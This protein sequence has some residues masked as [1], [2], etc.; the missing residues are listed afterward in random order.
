MHQELLHKNIELLRKQQPTLAMKLSEWQF[1]LGQLEVCKTKQGE[2]NLSEKV[3]GKICYFHSKYNA[4]KEAKDWFSSLN[5]EGVDVLYVYGIGM[6]HYYNA[7]KDWLD[8]SAGHYLVFIEDNL[9]V[10]R[11]FFNTEKATEVLE[12]KQVQ[13]HYLQSFVDSEA[14]LQWLSWFFVLLPID[15][16]GLLYYQK[17]KEKM[18]TQLRLKLMHDSVR[19]DNRAAEFMRFS[20]RFFK[21]FFSNTLYLPDSYHGNHLF[22]KFSGIP[23]IICGAGPSLDK[24]IAL[25]GKSL[26]QALVFSG[27]SALNALN[28]YDLLPH[29]SAGIDPNPAQY[30]RLFSNSSFELPFFYRGRMLHEAFRLIHGDRLYINGTGGYFISEWFEEKLGIESIIIDEGHN[31]VN[32]CVEIANA[33]GCNPIIFL[34][35]DL[36]YTGMN[37]YAKG[38]VKKRSVSKEQIIDHQGMDNSAFLR[39]DIYGK[40]IYTVWKWVTESDWIADYA[41]EHPDKTFINATEGGIGF[42]G[43]SNMLLSEVVKKYFTKQR[44]LRN[45][46]H[47]EIQNGVMPNV[48]RERILGLIEEMRGSL[49]KCVGLCEDLIK[50]IEVTKKKLER[51]ERLEQNLQTGKAA[52]YEVELTEEIAYQYILETIGMACTKI[53]EREY[54]QVTFDKSLTSDLQ[55]DLKRLEINKKKMMFMKQ[56]SLMTL[57]A[58][59]GSLRK[60]KIEVKVD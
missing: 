47:M 3:S 54:Y 56:A 10:I 41:K 31:V 25:L 36:A 50:E 6:G 53:M 38:I 34:G 19:K 35:M 17:K 60:E 57:E 27:G 16:S 42:S 28:A 23:A 59:Q 7:A 18:Y 11:H 49:E 33:L 45:R 8:E 44:D 43:V 2:L 21:N 9:S 5:L 46:I 52:L 48:T 30:Q 29:F 14:M 58:L 20:F 32:M 15:V 13:I 26:D 24:N 55:R 1:D 22:G 12:N 40:P 39:D 51:R 37:S 4:A